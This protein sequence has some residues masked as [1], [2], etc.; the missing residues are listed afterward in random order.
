M[1][2]FQLLSNQDQKIIVH[3]HEQQYS[4][5]QLKRYIVGFQS[6]LKTKKSKQCAI[7]TNNTLEFISGFLACTY[8]G[9]DVVLPPNNS[10]STLIQINADAY[11]GE[12][13]DSLKINTSENKIINN[14]IDSNIIIFT[15]GSTGKPKTIK[16]KV[17]QMMQEVEE[18]D[19]MWGKP[20][21]SAVFLSTVSY[22][23][24]YGLL[25][26]VM[27]PLTKGHAIWGKILPFE[28][29]LEKITPL[30]KHMV[31]ISSPAFIKRLTFSSL[32]ILGKMEVFSS[33]GALTVEQHSK[34]HIQLKSPI[35]QVYGSTETGGIAF[36][37]LNSNWQFFPS[38]DHK[39]SADILS[40]KSPF[41]YLN[42]WHNT[43]DIVATHK[44]GFELLG[45]L[46]RIVKIE[47]KRISLP[48]V[49]Q[50]LAECQYIKESHFIS[51]QNQRQYLAALI[52]MNQKGNEVLVQMGEKAMKQYIKSFLSDK[53]EKLAV[54]RQM[55]IVKEIPTNTQGKLLHDQIVNLFD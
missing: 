44:S 21:V 28:E 49:E 41:C 52:V 23:H 5:K 11:I 7:F 40:V 50:V 33:G 46:D 10:K 30:F 17:T 2:L 13:V 53:I 48:Q 22:Q 34:A 43:N 29:S 8:L 38:V 4:W 25:F 14:S 54:P 47:E 31:L 36:K 9:V 16:R 20:L 3:N 35:T 27:W 32:D 39:I 37:H 15:S 18:L 42:Q 19:N 55:R 24:I 51:R 12:F 1:D 45:R 26:S 6:Q